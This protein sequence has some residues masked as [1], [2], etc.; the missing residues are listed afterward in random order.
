VRSS[1]TTAMAMGDDKKRDDDYR[2]D[3]DDTDDTINLPGVVPKR[4]H[5]SIDLHLIFEEKLRVGKAL[6]LPISLNRI[7]FLI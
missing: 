7:L 5:L 1:T 6:P 3:D 2:S 4:R